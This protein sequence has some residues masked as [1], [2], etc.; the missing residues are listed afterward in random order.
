MPTDLSLIKTIVVVMMENRVSG[1][2]EPASQG[3]I[4]PASQIA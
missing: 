1:H 4:E 2:H 3:R